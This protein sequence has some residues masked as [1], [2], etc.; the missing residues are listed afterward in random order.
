MASE[1][2]F[3]AAM[4]IC[5]LALGCASTASPVHVDGSVP[6]VATPDVRDVGVD[7][8]VDVVLARDAPPATCPLPVGGPLRTP[9]A[10]G[11]SIVDLRDAPGFG[12]ALLH[13]GHI[14]CRGAGRR[15]V[16]ADGVDDP[17]GTTRTETLPGIDGVRAFDLNAEGAWAVRDDGSVWCWGDNREGRLH[18]ELAR[19]VLPP[20][21]VPG[22]E[23][24]RSVSV[25]HPS[26]RPCV[27]TGDG[28][29]RCW[30]SGPWPLREEFG[31]AI[32]VFSF[33]PTT[34]NMCARYPGD[35][36]YCQ[37]DNFA[38]GLNLLVD[39]LVAHFSATREFAC[40]VDR[41][42]TVSCWRWPVPYAKNT[43][44]DV[45]VGMRCATSIVVASTYVCASI[46]DGTVECWG[47]EALG[48]REHPRRRPGGS[49]VPGVDRI[50][51]MFRTTTTSCALRDDGDVWCW[52]GT[53]GTSPLGSPTG[54][55]L[56]F[57][58]SL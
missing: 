31:Q 17:T 9:E 32:E 25:G 15:G 13:D 28:L 33:A 27:V 38:L 46:T 49:G 47:D 54:A 20:T 42:R 40:G 35:R 23:G 22:V 50:V 19:E 41:T 18:P 39:G 6:D 37:G 2:G 56:P 12:C 24:V 30:G 55:G 45:D 10:S 4:V 11:A 8:P 26:L 16:F 44:Q 21:R 14:R 1:M 7:A 34:G 36:A 5:A 29:V 57:R 51:R 48:R 3:R 52:G 58:L 53:G 43:A